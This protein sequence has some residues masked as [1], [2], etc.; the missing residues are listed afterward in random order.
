MRRGRTIIESPEE[1]HRRALHARRSV[2]HFATVCNGAAPLTPDC[3]LGRFRYSRRRIVP[4]LHSVDS[5]A[6]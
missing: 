4:A 3:R 1:A 2:E 6:N 5:G